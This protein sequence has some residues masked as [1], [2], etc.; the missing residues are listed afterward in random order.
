[1][2]KMCSIS[3]GLVGKESH[4]LMNQIPFCWDQG[5]RE[6]EEGWTGMR[7]KSRRQ[8]SSPKSLLSR[9]LQAVRVRVLVNMRIG[10][11]G[12]SLVDSQEGRLNQP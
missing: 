10:K 6:N 2:G 9:E 11:K 3:L 5:Y 7:T 12:E 8:Q 1:M 4:L